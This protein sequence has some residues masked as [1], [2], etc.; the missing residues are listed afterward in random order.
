MKI[1][2]TLKQPVS[3][4]GKPETDDKKLSES[5][6]L[7]FDKHLKKIDGQNYEDELALL[8]GEIDKQGQKLSKNIDIKELIRYKKLISEFLYDAV[9]NSHKFHKE[10][11]LDRRG[12]HRVYAIISKVNENLER[13]TEE[14]LKEE[15]DNI[16]M[17]QR[18]DDIRGL[19]LDIFM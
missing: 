1:Q 19:L 7:T 13:I 3:V 10:S 11:M 16:K 12:R 2:D 17:L 15:K 4:Q 9:N 5:K 8:L 18:M 14:V 6:G